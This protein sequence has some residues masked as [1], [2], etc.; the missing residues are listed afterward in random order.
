M[1]KVVN[2]HEASRVLN[3]AVQTLRNWRTM[4]RGPSYLKMG[5]SVRYN[6]R[7]LEAYCQRKRV[8]PELDIIRS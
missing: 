1:E 5:G 3:L 8:D 7:D 4:R 2:E 6:L